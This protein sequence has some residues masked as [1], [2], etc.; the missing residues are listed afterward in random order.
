MYAP[1]QFKEER[2]EVLCSA[3]R[4]IQLAALVSPT[5]SGI[6]ISHVP[7]VV[8]E[9][10]GRVLLET[11][12]ARANPH[13]R[14]I[15]AGVASVAIFQGP[16]AYVTPS[17]YPSKKE[18]G[19]VVPT[20]TYIAVHAHG[21]LAS[22][23]DEA[24][25]RAHLDDLTRANEAAREEPWNLSDAPASFTAS[26]RRGIVGLRLTVD[27]VEGSWKINQHKNEA[28]KAGTAQGLASSG[29][30]GR[31]LASYLTAPTG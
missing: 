10:A 12:V 3:M 5:A 9:E 16:Q 25:L 13:W 20:W 17:W 23:T 22:V 31:E 8:K 6:E 24:W 21:M 11:H 28:D 14:V 26:L 15:N 18:H 19:K 7:M 29:E 30:M 4:S 2:V 1:Q 27:R